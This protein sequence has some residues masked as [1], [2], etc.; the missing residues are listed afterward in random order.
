MNYDFLLCG[1]FNSN[2]QSKRV[3]EKLDFKQYR[4][5]VFETRMDTKEP[6]ILS[7]LINPRKSIKFNFSH[8][9]TLIWKD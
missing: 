9:E 4:K 8:T 7:L 2:N 6:G 3:Q 1:Y 5:V